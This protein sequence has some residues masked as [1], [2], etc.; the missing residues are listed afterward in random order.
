MVSDR[1]GGDAFAYF[2]HFAG[3]LVAEHQRRRHRD[4]AVGRR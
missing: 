2:H 3:G 4:R 1:E